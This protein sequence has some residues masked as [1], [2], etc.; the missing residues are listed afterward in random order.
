MT[1]D[2]ER[3][4]R[5]SYTNDSATGC[6]W[7]RWCTTRSV[8]PSI[9]A[10]SDDR[11]SWGYYN[12]A[13]EVYRLLG[14]PDRLQ[15]ALTPNGNQ[16]NGPEVD[17]EWRAFFDRWLQPKP[18]PLLQTYLRYLEEGMARVEGALGGSTKRRFESPGDRAGLDSLSVR[19]ARGGR[20]VGLRL[21]S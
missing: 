19:S 4:R 5:K 14:V 6:R 11:Q 12:R 20:L 9:Y 1:S 18:S 13:K 16:A 7:Q 21:L 8:R 2:T 17:P 15:F 3:A 10:D